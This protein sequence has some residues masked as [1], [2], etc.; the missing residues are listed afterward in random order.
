MGGFCAGAG[1][2]FTESCFLLC[3]NEGEGNRGFAFGFGFGFGGF[4]GEC[5][6]GMA[7]AGLGGRP[8]GREGALLIRTSMTADGQSHSPRAR[9]SHNPRNPVNTIPESQSNPVKAGTTH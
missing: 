9:L 4:W 8:I 6:R 3:R 2:I 7:Q 5:G 1:G